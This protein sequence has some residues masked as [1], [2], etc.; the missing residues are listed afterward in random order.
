MPTAS[1][2]LELLMRKSNGSVKTKKDCQ[3]TDT[4]CHINFFLV[5]KNGNFTV[6]SVAYYF[7]VPAIKW[8]Y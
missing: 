8:S 6:L 4:R 2:Q 3:K 7:I 5:V 1:F